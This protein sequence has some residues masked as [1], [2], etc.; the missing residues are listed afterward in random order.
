LLEGSKDH[1]V[2]LQEAK[3]YFSEYGAEAGEAVGE[4]ILALLSN[5]EVDVEKLKAQES[6]LPPPDSKCLGLKSL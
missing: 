5:M 4:S 6:K 1:T 2:K 3:K